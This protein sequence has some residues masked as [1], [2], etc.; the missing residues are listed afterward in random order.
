MVNTWIL[1][2]QKKGLKSPLNY[3][4]KCLLLASF[5]PLY[6]KEWVHPKLIMLMYAIHMYVGLE[7]CLAFVGTTARALTYIHL[8]PQFD[9]PYL[10]TSLQDFWGRRW[11]LMVTSILHPAVYEP[12]RSIC[13]PWLGRRWAPLP[14]AFWTFV[15][16]GLMH[17][18]IFYYIG[19]RDPTWVVTCFFLLHGVSTVVEI[20]LKKAIRWRLPAGASRPLTVGYVAATGLWLFIPPLLACDAVPK[21]QRETLALIEVVKAFW[22]VLRFSSIAIL[23]ALKN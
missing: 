1:I 12:V 3:A 22:S 4:V 14:A 6:E 18:L 21:A 15:V 8:E 10:S 13:T 7:V 17:E 23:S 11:N 9:E 5:V 2:P 19:R 20:G 16:S